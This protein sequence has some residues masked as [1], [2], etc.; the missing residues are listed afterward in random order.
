MIIAQSL[1]SRE[2]LLKELNGRLPQLACDYVLTIN[3]PTPENDTAIVSCTLLITN[4][5]LPS[6]GVNYTNMSEIGHV[7][8]S[9]NFSSMSVS[10]IVP[11]DESSSFI[12]NLCG[13]QYHESGVPLFVPLSSLPTV[14]ISRIVSKVDDKE[15]ELRERLKSIKS[16]TVNAL[17]EFVQKVSNP[18]NVDVADVMNL[19]SCRF[20]Y[21]VPSVDLSSD[22]LAVYT[23]TIT[24]ESFELL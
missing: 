6:V 24:F 3:L 5:T 8:G 9:L 12:H 19:Y 13:T 10:F 1:L 21:P 15:K 17:K 20:S 7:K 18:S 14:K 4:F 11:S 22:S 2:A 16:D 23:T